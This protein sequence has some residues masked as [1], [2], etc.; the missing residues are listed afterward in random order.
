MAPRRH[1][2]HI[3]PLPA[4]IRSITAQIRAFLGPHPSKRPQFPENF[5]E[6]AQLRAISPAI[7]ITGCLASECNDGIS[8]VL[9][10]GV[11]F[12]CC[13]L[14]CGIGRDQPEKVPL[15]VS[16]RTKKARRCGALFLCR[17]RSISAS[18][19][20]SSSAP[21]PC[22]TSSAR[23][24]GCRGSGSRRPSARRAGWDRTVA[25]PSRSRASPHR[26]GPRG[27]RP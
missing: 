21:W 5:L 16:S 12:S 9:R 4:A 3:V 22:R 24:R 19:T 13:G 15:I 26:P 23:P 7:R 18:R 11:S 14:G 10:P 25:A 17:S 27:H 20:G 1:G 2:G 6:P 8:S